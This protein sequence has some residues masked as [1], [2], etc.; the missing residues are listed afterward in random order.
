MNLLSE[1]G[2]IPYI[3]H[4]SLRA[5]YDKKFVQKEL[6]NTPAGIQVMQR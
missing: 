1:L 5:Q 2:V 4:D 6:R 3:S